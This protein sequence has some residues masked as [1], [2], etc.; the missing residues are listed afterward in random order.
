LERIA[1]VPIYFSDAIARRSPPLQE[2]ADAAAPRAWLSPVLAR[3]IGV[4]EGMQVRV[5]QGQGSGVFAA[6]IDAKLPETVVRLST[7]HDTTKSLGGMF[8]AVSVEKV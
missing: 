6:G 4:S 1:D 2:T 5:T 7:S 3:Q 8:G